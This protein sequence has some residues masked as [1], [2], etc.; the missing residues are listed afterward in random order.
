M[1]FC[2]F[3]LSQEMFDTTQITNNWGIFQGQLWRNGWRLKETKENIGSPMIDLCHTKR[4]RWMIN[5][6]SLSVNY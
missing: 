6:E 2:G 5:G 4:D 1:I 3:K